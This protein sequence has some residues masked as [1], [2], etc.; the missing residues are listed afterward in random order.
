[1]KIQKFL[2]LLALLFLAACSPGA[3]T[4]A[5]GETAPQATAPPAA[6][7]TEPP[8]E[9]TEPPAEAT[10][11]PAPE[12]TAVPAPAF[13]VIG[14]VNRDVTQSAYSPSLTVGSTTPGNP[15][16]L[17]IAWAENFSADSR[18]IFASELVDGVLQPRGA[19]LNIHLNVIATSPGI[20]FAGEGNAVPWVTW[21]EPSPGFGDIINTFASRFNAA[22]GLWVPAGQD[23]GGGEPS[24]NSSTGRDAA[25]AVIT[26]GTGDP[27]APPL[28]WVAWSEFGRLSG[29]T[30]I[31]VSKGIKDETG[32]GGFI[33]ELVGELRHNDEPTLN[34]DPFRH[35]LGASI[36]FAETG[37][38]V[39]WVTWH[40][41][42]GDRPARIFT[43]RGVADANAPGGF[44]WVFVPSCDPDETACSLNINPLKDA[45]DA[46]MAA[47]SVTPGEATVPWIT[48]SEIGPSGK[49]QV[50]VSRLDPGTRASFVNVGGSLNVDQ[51]HDARQPQIVFMGNVPYVAWLEEDGSGN[52]RVQVRHLSS[53]P[54]TGTWTLDS[55]ES[56]FDHD[57]ELSNSGLAIAASADT[58]FLAWMEGDP[59]V[60]IAQVVL[61]SFKP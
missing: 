1:M 44:R 23:R 60:T 40:E 36:V 29:F 7:A 20:A 26:G 55:P 2:L 34:V 15:P 49:W 46:T 10:E 28:P 6:E 9:A 21:L 27:A 39:P 4:P 33:W 18:Q 35:G 5:G 53:D 17:W 52:F 11:P 45:L 30:Q 13:Q 50:F 24:L 48:W 31:F 54:Q 42:G 59:A 61:A 3:A 22:S 41:A 38:A 16:T 12:P 37:N 51:N 56:G 32:I 58:L 19:S 47:G 43:A 25:D 8:A 14:V 57:P